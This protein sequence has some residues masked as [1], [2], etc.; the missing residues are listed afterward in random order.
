M[1]TN[2]LGAA[3]GATVLSVVVP[4]RN[5]AGNVEP[6]V[7]GIAAAVGEIPTEVIFVDDSID[8]TPAILDTLAADPPAGVVIRVIHRPA[9]RHNGLGAAAVEGLKVAEGVAVAVMDGDLQHPPEMLPVML[10]TLRD[11]R[12]DL[13]VASRYARGGSARG[14]NGPARRF[15][16]SLSRRFSQLLF[17]E[18]RKT[19]DPLSGYFLCRQSTIEGLE[20]R[21]IGFK[22]LLEVLVCTPDAIVG[23]VPLRFGKRGAGRSNASMAQGWLF[24]K[25]VGTLVMQVRGSARFWKYAVVGGAGLAVFLGLLLL[26]QKLGLGAFQAWALA[27]VVSLFLNWQLNRV[28]TFADVSSPFTPGRDR[29][30]YLPMALLGGCANLVVFAAFQTRVSLVLAGLAGAAA[31]MAVNFV[32]QR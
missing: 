8:E 9:E 26:G 18:A 11:D 15:V 22:V 12:L 24:L 25:H 6:L 19:S 31:A 20:F 16:S 13:V 2:R 5:E 21:P 27:F 17:R 29:P 3:G 30:V 32:A 7:A 10:E 23:E 14:L 28:F 1:S 4:T